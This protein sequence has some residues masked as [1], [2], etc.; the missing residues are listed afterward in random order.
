MFFFGVSEPFRTNQNTTANLQLKGSTCIT[1]YPQLFHQILHC[2]RKS[3]YLKAQFFFSRLL[4][5]VCN[6][7]LQIYSATAYPY[8][9]NHHFCQESATFESHASHM[10]IRTSAIDSRN[11]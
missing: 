7:F 3:A 6:F 11:V 9:R 4:P 5:H 2:K 8:I 1:D 10:H